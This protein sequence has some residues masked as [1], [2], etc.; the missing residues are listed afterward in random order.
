MYGTHEATYEALRFDV[1][2][3]GLLSDFTTGKKTVSDYIARR[4]EQT[5]N[6]PEK[7]L[8]RD[9]MG[10]IK[11]LTEIDFTIAQ[12][13]LAIPAEGKAGL[14]QFIDFTNVR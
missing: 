7:W 10:L 13:V 2:N 1:A 12:Q 14:H 5:L 6:L 4:I 11:R 9:N 3:I 8:D